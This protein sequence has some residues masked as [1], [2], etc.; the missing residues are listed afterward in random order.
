FPALFRNRSGGSPLRFW[1]PGCSTGE[2]VY[3]LT[4]SLLAGLSETDSPFPI[5]IFG[6]DVRPKAIERARAGIYLE[7]IAADVSPTRL[8]RFF[9][10]TDDRFQVSKAGRDLCIFAQHD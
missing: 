1:V 9:V 7:S 3:S 5:Q 10:R 2:E 6:T 4:I 8:E